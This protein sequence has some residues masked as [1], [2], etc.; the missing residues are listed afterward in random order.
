MKFPISAV[1]LTYNEE[2]NIEDCLKSVCGFI[3]DI[4]VVD[5]YSV[6][7]TLEIVKKY[8][9]NI[10]QHEFEN[11]GK[12]R[13]WALNNLPITTEWI[14]NLNSDQRFTEDLKKELTEIFFSSL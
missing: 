2:K 6:D 13:N 12:Q 10:V 14:L 7:K 3:E 5:S 11:Y 9:N 1:I 4:F 8:T